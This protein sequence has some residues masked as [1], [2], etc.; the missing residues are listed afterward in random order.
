LLVSYEL[1]GTSKEDLR[2]RVPAQFEFLGSRDVVK[3]TDADAQLSRGFLPGIPAS[4]SNIIGLRS[5]VAG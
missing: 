1:V 4:G 3:P 5:A 2:Q